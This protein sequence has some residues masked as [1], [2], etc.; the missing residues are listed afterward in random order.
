[1]PDA[2]KRQF[3]NLLLVNELDIRKLSESN[4]Y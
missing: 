2:E 3:A 1:M 4:W